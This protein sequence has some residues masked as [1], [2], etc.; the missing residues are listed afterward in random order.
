M[1]T[2]SVTNN[3]QRENG[4]VAESLK[5]PGPFLQASYCRESIRS[6]LVNKISHLFIKDDFH[7]K[8]WAVLEFLIPQE[9]T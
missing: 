1:L 6:F 9:V 5:S 7:F 4:Q 8:I 2:W 3:V